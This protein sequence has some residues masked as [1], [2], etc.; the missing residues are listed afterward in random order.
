MPSN[1]SRAA[2]TFLLVTLN[3][4]T[5]WSDPGSGAIITDDEPLP[6]H[7]L[8]MTEVFPG[9][10]EPE[11]AGVLFY[12]PPEGV[13]DDFNLLDFFDIPGAFFNE[14]MSVSTRSIRKDPD[15]GPPFQLL[16]K[17]L[18]DV[19]VWLVDADDMADAIADG[20]LTM[21]ELIDIPSLVVGKAT[22]FN[23]MIQPDPRDPRQVTITAQGKLED[24][25]TFHIK[26]GGKNLVIEVK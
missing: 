21:P 23:E 12:R 20:E 15:L 11:W 18:G 14:P 6:F 19:A 17:G 1:V 10:R 22:K 4:V 26:G 25:R 3:G 8:V 9:N 16:V 2:A 5:A 7:A 13:A 24:G